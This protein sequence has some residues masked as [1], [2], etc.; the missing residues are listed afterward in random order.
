MHGFA[1]ALLLDTSILKSLRKGYVLFDLFGEIGGLV[2][3][4][5]VFIS[6]IIAPFP[7]EEMTA[8]SSNH[9]YS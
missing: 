7:S 5:Y 9:L 8:K 1:I 2:E 4:F 6:V 3:F